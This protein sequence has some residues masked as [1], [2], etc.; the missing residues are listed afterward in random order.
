MK[1]ILTVE[2][3]YNPRFTDPEGLAVALDRLLE[4][5]LSTP[6]I[7]SEYGNP[8]FGEFFVANPTPNCKPAP[9]HVV[10]NIYGGV[11]LE[12]FCDDP[13]AK[14]IKIDWD[15]EGS[16]PTEKGIVEFTDQSGKPQLAFVAEFP[17]LPLKY[18]AETD[19]STVL[20][21]AGV[22]WRSPKP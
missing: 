10:L 1:T 9:P 22:E 11:L 15:T 2:V 8:A 20:E 3:K 13:L 19:M 21:A 14:T 18:L 6:D 12:V 4:T 17:V 16:G 5:A 7:L